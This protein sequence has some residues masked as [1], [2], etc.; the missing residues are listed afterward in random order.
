MWSKLGIQYVSAFYFI[1]IILKL[2]F[3]CR[4]RTLVFCSLKGKRLNEIHL[5]EDIVDIE[6]FN[7]EPRQYIGVLVALKQEV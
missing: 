1:R 3:A 4:D 5:D 6:E 2:V 7:Y